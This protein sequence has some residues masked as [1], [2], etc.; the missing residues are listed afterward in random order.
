MKDA[1]TAGLGNGAGVGTVIGYDANV[2]SHIILSFLKWKDKSGATSKDPK[3]VYNL[4][5]HIY[6]K[7][8][9]LW[10]RWIV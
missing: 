5:Y 1:E 7:N 4:L 6:I 8:T 3:W 2:R 9:N 10:Y